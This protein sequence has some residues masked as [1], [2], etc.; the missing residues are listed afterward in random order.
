[1]RQI[2]GAPQLLIEQTQGGASFR[3]W[4]SL[5]ACER[6]VVLSITLGWPPYSIPY[7]LIL[8][9]LYRTLQYAYAGGAGRDVFPSPGFPKCIQTAANRNNTLSSDPMNLNLGSKVAP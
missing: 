7:S 5:T 2:Q 6:M 1:M 9:L 8:Y 3:T 4:Q